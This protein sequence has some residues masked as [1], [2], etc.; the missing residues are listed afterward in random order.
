MMFVIFCLFLSGLSALDIT[1]YW[2]T[3]DDETG[4]VKSICAVYEKN[5]KVFGRLLVLFKDGQFLEDYRNPVKVAEE[6]KGKP[7]YSGMDIIW[8]MK[9]VGNK[10]K[11]GKIIDPEK[12]SIYDC[13]LWLEEGNLKVRGFFM[14]IG[15]NQTWLPMDGTEPLPSDLTLPPLNSFTPV[16]PR[17]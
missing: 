12:G 11:K 15:R 6:T 16:I 4:E 3:V 17:K 9:E 1:G 2:K 13:E 7:F 5:G 10:Y 8:N 14:F